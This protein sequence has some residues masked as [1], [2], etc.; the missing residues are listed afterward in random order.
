M[1]APGV[2]RR[3]G[4][5]ALFGVSAAAPALGQQPARPATTLDTVRVSVSSRVQPSS[6]PLARTVEVIGRAEIDRMPARTL[7]D[8]LAR[9]LGA[10]LLSRSPASADLAIRGSSFEQVV[11]LVDGVRVSDDQTG[12]FD[13]DL[14]VPLDLVERVE[15]LRGSGSALYGP[16]AVGGVV[17]VVTSRGAGGGRGSPGMRASG[18]V[19]G[20]GFGTV[21]GSVVGSGGGVVVGGD[22][23][24]SSGHRPGTDLRVE[25]VRAGWDV[26]TPIGRVGAHA[27]LGVRDF[28]AADFYAPFPSHERTG[29]ATAAVRLRAQ[30]HARWQVAATANVRRHT[31]RFTLKRSDP[32]FYQNRHETWQTGG[33]AVAH[34]AATDRA[35]LAVGVEAYGSALESA[36]LGDRSESRGALFSEVTAG[37]PGTGSVNAGVRVDRSSTFG[38]VV[39]PSLAGV[40]ALGTKVRVRASGARAFRNPTWTERYYVDPA[41]RGDS[42]L[43]PETF[44]TGEVGVSAGPSRG[45]RVDVAA[46]ARRARAL[47][48]WAKPAGA[49]ADVPWQTLNVERATFRGVE[50]KAELPRMLGASWMVR[51]MGLAVDGRTANGYMG[52]Y[53]LRPITRAASVA[54]SAPLLPATTLTLEATHARRLAEAGYVR[55]DVR[56]AYARHTVRVTLDVLNLT[57]T[58]YLDAAA[59][60]VAPRAAYLGLEVRPRR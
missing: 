37:D 32:G 52:K 25:Q 60:P 26:A 27:G 48:D 34:V 44:W 19:L 43:R 41:N 6:L 58:R 51:G 46:F 49:A 2:A 18:R 35:A 15:I 29:T 21:G 3:L 9:S 8:V 53:A 14:A 17:N 23:L 11:V 55:A 16:D 42:T 47:I 28:G 1:T 13:L 57:E 36:R 40:R 30:P 22:F 56:L 24:R 12:H 5:L 33:E 59:Q 31:D 7:A 38:T 45:P 4:A 10:D 50:L 39:S 54:V 20:G